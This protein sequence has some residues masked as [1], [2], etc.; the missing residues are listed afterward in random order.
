MHKRKEGLPRER[1]ENLGLR[2]AA[3]KKLSLAGVGIVDI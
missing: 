3:W 2:V 1:V